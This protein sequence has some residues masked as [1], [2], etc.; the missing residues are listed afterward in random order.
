MPDMKIRTPNLFSTYCVILVLSLFGCSKVDELLTFFISD[1]T[2]FRIESSSPLDLPFEIATPDVT[3]NSSQKFQNNN[4]SASK[5]KDVKLEEM[6][7]TV[8]NPAGKNFNFLKSCKV[9]ISTTQNNEILLASAENIPM[10]VT[11][12][13][14]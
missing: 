1:Q 8:T 14:L 4:T 10:N 3:T 2:S 7:L 11:T 12:V 9:Y 5:V 6:R 13:T